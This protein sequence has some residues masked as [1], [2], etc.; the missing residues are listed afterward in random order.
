ERFWWGSVF[1]LGVPV[2]VLL[3]VAAPAVLPE[4][5]DPHP[6]RLDLT[7]VLLALATVVPIVYGLKELAADGWGTTSVAAV[8]LGVA[9]GVLFVRRQNRLDDPMLDLTLFRERAFSVGLSVNLGG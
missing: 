8:L 5:R 9:M 3:L 2:M 7:S 6:G 1:L 4:S